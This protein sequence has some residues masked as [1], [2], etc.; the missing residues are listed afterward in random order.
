MTAVRKMK[1]YQTRA[2]SY[3]KVFSW[4]AAWRANRQKCPVCKTHDAI[5]DDSLEMHKVEC[6]LCGHYRISRTQMRCES[7][8]PPGWAYLSGIGA[9][10]ADQG[11][12]AMSFKPELK[13]VS[14]SGLYPG[15]RALAGGPR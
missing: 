6:P 9:D 1:L 2:K 10:A 15:L 7:N 8:V 12:I 5:I 11:F 3:L 4:P 14:D 13:S